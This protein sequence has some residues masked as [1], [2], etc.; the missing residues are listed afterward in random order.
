MIENKWTESK[1]EPM[2]L[3]PYWREL[4]RLGMVCI[5]VGNGELEEEK[6]FIEARRLGFEGKPQEIID[7]LVVE[8]KEIQ[9]Y[10][11]DC[12]DEKSL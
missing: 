8:I 5:A 4:T 3:I 9:S 12:Y 1:V 11:L 6:G 7:S 10:W 2:A